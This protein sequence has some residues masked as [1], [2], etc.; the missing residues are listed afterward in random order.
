MGDLNQL[1]VCWESKRAGCKQTSRLLE[2]TEDNFL[3]QVLKKAIRGEALLDLVLIMEEI[4]KK[5]KIGRS[6][7]CSD[8]VLDKF[9]NVGLTKSGVSTLNFRKENLRLFKEFLDEIPWKTFLGTKEKNKVG[10]TLRMPF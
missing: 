3:V 2:C 1:D 5:D 7:G 10:S 8:H 9:G 4:V 6:L